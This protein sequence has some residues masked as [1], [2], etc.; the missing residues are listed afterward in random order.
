MFSSTYSSKWLDGSQTYS[1]LQFHFHHGSEHTIDG[2]R[3]D[4]EMHTVHIANDAQRAK[5][6]GF[7]FAALGVLFSVDDYT[8][9]LSEREQ[10]I[11]DTFFESMGWGSSN[12]K[13]SK[14]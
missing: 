9:E 8:I 11:I 10:M 4:L 2:K 7:G 14:I 5:D 1:G 13:G 3:H 12:V 6:S